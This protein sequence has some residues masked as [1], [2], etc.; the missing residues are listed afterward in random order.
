[1]VD[2]FVALAPVATVGNMKSPIKY[3]SY[4]SG[5]IQVS[6]LTQIEA[7]GKKGFLKCDNFKVKSVN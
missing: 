7:H 4:F 5:G 6:L 3:L 2:L 1:M